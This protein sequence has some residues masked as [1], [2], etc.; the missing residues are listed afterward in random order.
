MVNLRREEV[1]MKKYQWIKIVDRNDNGYEYETCE[2]KKGIFGITIKIPS[3]REVHV[4]F[5]YSGI[6]SIRSVREV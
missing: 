1:V 4:F 2:M 6:I 3:N 5:P